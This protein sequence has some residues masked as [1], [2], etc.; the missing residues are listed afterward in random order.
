MRPPTSAIVLGVV[1]L[2]LGITACC[3]A[4]ARPTVRSTPTT[5]PNSTPSMVRGLGVERFALGAAV[6]FVTLLTSRWVLLAVAMAALAVL[7][8]RLMRD[9]R[10]EVERR[11]VEAIATWLED[12]RDTLRGSSIGA[13]EALEQVAQRPPEALRD[14]L[15]TYAVRRRQGLRTED[16]LSELAEQIAHPTSDAAVAAI[17]LVVTGSAGSGRLFST[18][19]ALAAA[20]RDEVRARERIDRTRSIYQSSMKRLVVIAVALIAYLR[21]AA[22]PLLDPYA[23]PAGQIVLA[24]PLGM[25]VACVMWLRRMCRYEEPRRY[26]IVGSTPLPPPLVPPLAPPLVPPGGPAR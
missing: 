17:R 20:A 11:R 5:R 2:A 18:V 26:R 24:I 10:A 16:A 8:D 6:G 23:T 4:A 14:A 21:F 12:L 15:A 1:V 3:V 9:G 25:W 13:E 7:W 19:D 22:G